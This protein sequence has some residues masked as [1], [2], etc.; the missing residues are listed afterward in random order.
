MKAS[1]LMSSAPYI[2]LVL[3]LS[4]TMPGTSTSGYHLLEKVSLAP[5]PGN[6]EYFDYIA[7]APAARRIY[8]TH[9]TEVQ[10][11]D[12][13]KFSTVGAI[14]GF[15]RCHGVAV[16][17]EL[18]KGYVT[19]E[20]AGEVIVFDLKSLRVT[21]SI[22]TY[23]DAD[24]V[25][26][27]P[28]SKLLFS[29]NGDSKNASVIDPAK[30]AVIKTIN[31]GGGPEQPVADGSGMLYDNNAETNEVV[32]IDTRALAIKA[33]WPV[34][35]AGEPVAM[36]MDRKHRRLFSAT[37]A[38]QKLLM[39]DA[40]NGRVLQSFPISDGVDATIYDSETGMVFA[41]TRAGMIHV[42]HED[43]A[44]KLSVVDTIKTEYGAK[45][46]AM[47]PKTHNLIL[48]TADFTAVSNS[49]DRQAVKGTAHLLIYGR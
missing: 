49:K 5:A 32:V 44:N 48:V 7:V 22:K 46:M 31:L 45:T 10:V 29:F 11:F 25:I 6:G 37:R 14:T 33:R 24:G 27:D 23:P 40:D 21:G 17:P 8:V 2:C 9:G 19:D 39:M 1:K 15:T 4:T 35:P 18:G 13:D 36:A 43:S 38:P 12:A 47:D 34:A 26:Y 41:S 28:A 30:Q 16:L 42:F 3:L 20:A